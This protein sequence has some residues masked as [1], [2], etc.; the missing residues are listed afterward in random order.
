MGCR[1]ALWRGS[2]ALPLGSGLF[3]RADPGIGCPLSAFFRMR[4]RCFLGTWRLLVRLPAFDKSP[5]PPPTNLI[6][7]R[8]HPKRL[9]TT[10]Q[11]VHACLIPKVGHHCSH[12]RQRTNFLLR[13]PCP[14][15]HDDPPKRGHSGSRLVAHHGYAP[16]SATNT[17][18]M[19]DYERPQSKN[20]KRRK[21]VMNCACDRRNLREACH[22]YAQMPNL[23]VTKG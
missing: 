4:R 20:W 13:T 21:F 16:Q 23:S 7:V 14:Q 3:G 11:R 6:V 10:K 9:P 18:R 22:H 19:V 2:V 1:P 17:T 8:V 12:P 5:W 15:R